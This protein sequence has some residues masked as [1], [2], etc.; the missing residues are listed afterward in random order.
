MFGADFESER[1]NSIDDYKL[2]CIQF[3][4]DISSDYKDWVDR[5]KLPEHE[6][7]ARKNS[8]DY[9]VKTTSEWIAWYGNTIRKIDIIKDDG[10]NKMAEFTAGYP[11]EFNV[12]VE[13]QSRYVQAPPMIRLDISAKPREQRNI[14]I[15]YWTREQFVQLLSSC[16]VSVNVE[17]IDLLPKH[18]LDQCII[19][20][21]CLCKAGDVI[22][23]TIAVEEVSEFGT[24]K[25]G[26]TTII[27]IK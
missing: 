9:V 20:D 22:S 17:Q 13:G 8:I 4:E 24:E 11:F 25:R 26:L 15:S 27:R 12:Y 21:A 16:K 1:A 18:M 19:L 6:S 2:T 3:I 10:I 5:Y 7:K 14:R 23:V